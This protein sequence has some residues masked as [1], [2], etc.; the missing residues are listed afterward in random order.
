MFLISFFLKRYVGWDMHTPLVVN[1]AVKE[2]VFGS[3]ICIFLQLTRF[4]IAI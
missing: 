4:V 2:K 1:V 3:E